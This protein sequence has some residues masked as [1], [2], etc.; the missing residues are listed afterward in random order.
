MPNALRQSII[1]LYLLACLLLGGS[2]RAPWPNMALQLGAVAILAWAALAQP[3]FQSGRPGAQLAVLTAAMVGLIVVQL[4][5]LPPSLWSA[6]PGRGAIAHGFDLLG[7]P[8]PWLPLSLAPYETLT[9]A[10]WLLPP[11]AILAGMLRLGAFRE[12]WMAM[13]IVLAAVAGVILGTLQ[14]TSADVVTSHWYP[15]AITNNGSLAGFFANSNH[16]A[17][18]LVSTLPFLVAMAGA[19]G[20]GGSSRRAHSSAGRLAIIGGAMLV[21]GLGILLNRSLAG[22][23]LG[24]VVLGASALVRARL[25]R[26][27]ARWGLAAVGVAGLLAVAA[28]IAS[29]MQN[30]LTAAGAEHEYSSR[31]TSFSN[32]LSATADHFPVGSGIGSFAEIYPAYENPAWV[33]RWFVN[34][35]HNDYIE[36]ALET[37]LPGMLLIA[38]FLLWW[39]QRTVAIWRAPAIDHFARAATI[40]SGAMLLHSLVDFPLRSTGI[41][42]LFAFCIA[43]MVGVRRRTS[44]EVPVV[45]NAAGARHLSIG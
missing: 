33:D 4:V 3:R 31:Y 18:L 32:S 27:I 13:A 12:Q 42:A 39:M 26:P 1:P 8:R 5:P 10:L 9:S 34:H 17:T 22:L 36:L 15:Y 38:A 45:E 20:R 21:I 7:Q 28:I 37:G 23:A 11:L 30:N 43:L 29:P 2:T 19:G 16:M 41:S 35:V 44:V 24:L 6:L 14:I 40:A 25:D